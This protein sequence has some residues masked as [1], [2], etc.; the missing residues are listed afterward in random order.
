MDIDIQPK[1]DVNSFQSIENIKEQRSIIHIE[2]EDQKANE[3]EESKIEIGGRKDKEIEDVDEELKRMF[4]TDQSGRNQ[5]TDQ[6]ESGEK[7]L[8]LPD[9]EPYTD[10]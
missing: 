5:I 6:K 2:L 3:K 8:M 1:I 10:E 4:S 7:R 9:F